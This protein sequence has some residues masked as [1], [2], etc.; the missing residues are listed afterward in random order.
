MPLVLTVKPGDILRAGGL[1]LGVQ[2]KAQIVIHEGLVDSLEDEHGNR[3]WPPAD[4][5][6]PAEPYPVAMVWTGR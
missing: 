4:D 2:S 3:R 6:D 5:P 1:A